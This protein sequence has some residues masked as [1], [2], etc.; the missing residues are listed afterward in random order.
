MMLS[1]EVR[2]ILEVLVGVNALEGIGKGQARTR[3]HIFESKRTP[4]H[5]R[6]DV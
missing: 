5:L 1:Q 3:P 4:D 2:R 6:Q